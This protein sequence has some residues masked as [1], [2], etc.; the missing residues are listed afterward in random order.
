MS[1]RTIETVAVALI[2]QAK[3]GEMSKQVVATYTGRYAVQKPGDPHHRIY[4]SRVVD[5]AVVVFVSIPPDSSTEGPQGQIAIDIDGAADQMDYESRSYL[6]PNPKSVTIMS[7]SETKGTGG[8][9]IA[10]LMP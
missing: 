6:L 10:V 4:V 7:R 2:R 8:Y 5:G 9:S 1:G 3:G